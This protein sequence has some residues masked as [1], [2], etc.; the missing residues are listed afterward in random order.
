MI[1]H[2]TV[3]MEKEPFQFT[4]QRKVESKEGGIQGGLQQP[5][6]VSP[7]LDAK[8]STAPSSEAASLKQ[9]PGQS[10]IDSNDHVDDILPTPIGQNVLVGIPSTHVP[11]NE[12][13]LSNSHSLTSLLGPLNAKAPLKQAP[14]LQQQQRQQQDPEPA[15][16]LARPIS[17]TSRP[18]TESRRAQRWKNRY[19]DLVRFKAEHGH[20]N[21]S[22]SSPLVSPQLGEFVKRQRRQWLLKHENKHST[23]TDEREKALDDLG[24]C[25]DY[26]GKSWDERY[27]D[28]V[29]YR[30]EDGNVVIRKE[31]PEHRGL[32]A[33]LKRQRG[34]CRLFLAG[35]R[36]TQMTEE[37]MK[38]LFELGVTIGKAKKKP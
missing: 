27:Q 15:S 22:Y 31:K 20:C 12:G 9:F 2:Y 5:D 28:L 30:N 10:S 1:V 32:N 14:P 13:I 18:A 33:W 25:W 24:F 23:L 3:V 26:R 36:S 4:G 11:F 37:R 35:D 17:S 16:T 38:K 19:D 29:T 6:F 7:T 21:I 34:F 8:S